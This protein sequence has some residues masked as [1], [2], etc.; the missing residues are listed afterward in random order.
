LVN[1]TSFANGRIY[2]C[3]TGRE[4]APDLPPGER[5]PGFVNSSGQWVFLSD[6]ENPGSSVGAGYDIPTK[7]PS[8]LI[9]YSKLADGSF[10]IPR[11]DSGRLYFFIG[12]DAQERLKFKLVRDADLKVQFQDPSGWS[13][14]PNQGFWQ[15]YEWCEFTFDDAGMHCNSTVVDQ[16]SIPNM[17]TLTGKQK[18]IQRTG[19]L[20]PG[21]RA[22]II[23]EIT[24][25][26]G[27]E[28]LAISNGGWPAT[29][30]PLRLLSPAKGLEYEPE[31][32]GPKAFDE[33]YLD[34]YIRWA[35][36]KYRPDRGGKTLTVNF[37]A[38]G[39][40]VSYTGTVD[41]QDRFVFTGGPMT[42]APVLFPST[43]DVLQCDGNLKADN[44]HVNGPLRA[45]IAAALN[46]TTL[47]VR[48][49]QPTY[50]TSQYYIPRTTSDITN[51][52]AKIMHKYT[53]DHKAYG[54]AFDDVAEQAAY[55][56]DVEPT[57]WKVTLT[58]W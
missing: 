46:R 31:P 44:D 11:M 9:P 50:D 7:Y 13:G 51:Y 23:S 12:R 55:V 54:F 43:A 35:W 20:V 45:R 18:G 47:G 15:L 42:A 34:P 57:E 28:R 25:T 38:S 16:F 29:N 58:K 1:Q 37:E 52:Y 33:H 49:N 30:T 56:E 24:S 4:F 48:H 8:F 36:D 39:S 32:G 22:K 5:R 10:T 21:S 27:Y 19:E 26:P 14:D 40:A 53:T 17:V 41:T 2:A 3:I 6:L